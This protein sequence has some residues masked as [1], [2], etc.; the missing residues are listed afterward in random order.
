MEGMSAIEEKWRDLVA[1]KLYRAM[2]M[3]LTWDGFGRVWVAF[4]ERDG[5][6]EVLFHEASA[7]PDTKD[8]CALKRDHGQDC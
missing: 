5:T 1:I 8:I 2:P 7:K 4:M 6:L 3:G